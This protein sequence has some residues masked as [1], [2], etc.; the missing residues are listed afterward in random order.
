MPLPPCL[1]S[2]GPQVGLNC[3]ILE[4][5]QVR[6]SAPCRSDK[7]RNNGACQTETRR[8]L[9][10]CTPQAHNA[11]YLR[12]SSRREWTELLRILQAVRATVRTPFWPLSLPWQCQQRRTKPIADNRIGLFRLVNFGLTR[13]FDSDLLSRQLGSRCKFSLG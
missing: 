1:P 9:L 7:R 12:R 10:S 4:V 2:D 8:S 3:L 11:S 6:T 13:S 5:L